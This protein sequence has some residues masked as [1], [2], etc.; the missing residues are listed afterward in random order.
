MSD[1]VHALL[2]ASGCVLNS[3]RRRDFGE[4]RVERRNHHLHDFTKDS[5]E[6]IVAHLSVDRFPLT[7]GIFRRALLIDKA[8][9]FELAVRLDLTQ[10]ALER[11]TRNVECLIPLG[12]EI[13][14]LLSQRPDIDLVLILKT[15]DLWALAKACVKSREAALIALARL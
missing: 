1:L 10:R 11:R 12:D 4:E 5:F 3:S 2:S 9:G 6:A 14:D 15:V 7:K 13:V 8:L